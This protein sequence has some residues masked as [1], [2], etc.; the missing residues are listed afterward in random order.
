MASGVRGEGL[1]KLKKWPCGG[2]GG[3]GFIRICW[4]PSVALLRKISAGG[5]ADF[6]TCR[7]LVLVDRLPCW[8]LIWP[9]RTLKARMPAPARA[10]V[11]NSKMVC[12]KKRC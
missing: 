5:G 10:T 8:L 12:G 11:E 1:A 6:L 3:S 2:V 7:V 9:L 4:P